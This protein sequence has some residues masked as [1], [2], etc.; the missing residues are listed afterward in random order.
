MKKKKFEVQVE[1]VL[2]CERTVEAEDM[3]EAE[4]IVS[5]MNASEWADYAVNEEVDEPIIVPV[6]RP[7]Q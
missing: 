3:D 5:G 2:T 4:E 6:K 1:V 7:R